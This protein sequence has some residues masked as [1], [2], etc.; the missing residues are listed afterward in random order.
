MNEFEALNG[1]SE[2][3]FPRS[4]NFSLC[5]AILAT[6]MPEAVLLER[7]T[8]EFWEGSGAWGQTNHAHHS[9]P[10]EGASHSNAATSG[11]DCENSLSTASALNSSYL[12]CTPVRTPHPSLNEIGVMG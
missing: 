2:D 10:R 4:Q 7:Q 3:V 5:E 6:L 9:F 1:F 11:P 8:D 12:A